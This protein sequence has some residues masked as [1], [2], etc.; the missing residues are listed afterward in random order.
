MN[1]PLNTSTPLVVTLRQEVETAVMAAT[2]RVHYEQHH[3]AEPTL[4]DVALALA[5][6]D[7][8]PLADR[9]D[10]IADA[11]REVAARQPDGDPDDVILLAA[12]RLEGHT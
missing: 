4:G 1:E 3:D 10:L 9:P 8:S 11:A 7:G 5:F 6:Q 12:S 2:L